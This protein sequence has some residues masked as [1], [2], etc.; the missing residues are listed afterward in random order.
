MAHTYEELKG[1]TVV[2][3]RDIAKELTHEAVRGYTQ[4]NKEHLL[5]AVC[6]ALG[7]DA[8]A[9]H[10]VVGLDKAGIKAKIRT[11]KL[12]RDKALEAHDHEKLRAIRRQIHHMKRKIHQAT[13]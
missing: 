3:L 1:M 10:H 7:V 13:V 12:E 2:Q 11:L 6:A 4:L 9:H 5:V 8:H